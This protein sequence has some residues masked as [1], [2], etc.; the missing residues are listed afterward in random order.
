MKE[1]QR[2][3]SL[4]LGFVVAT[5]EVCTVELLRKTASLPTNQ[6][7][8]V[9]LAVEDDDD[10]STG[11]SR[12]QEGPEDLLDNLG[13]RSSSQRQKLDAYPSPSCLLCNESTADW[14]QNRS[15]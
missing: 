13:S 2:R 4:T 10:R 8:R 5:A 11:A 9:G 14:A 1:N 3:R 6:D 15:E 7:G 12:N